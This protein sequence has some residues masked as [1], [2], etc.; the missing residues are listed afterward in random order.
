[1]WI[2]IVWLLWWEHQWIRVL[3]PV[4]ARHQHTKNLFF[5]MCVCVL[6]WRL[7]MRDSPH[8]CVCVQYKSSYITM[9]Q[10]NSETTVFISIHHEKLWVSPH[11]HELFRVHLYLFFQ[12]IDPETTA[13][14]LWSVMFNSFIIVMGQSVRG[15]LECYTQYY[16]VWIICIMLITIIIKVW[17]HEHDKGCY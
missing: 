12:D 15:L 11:T 1:M 13:N 2:D 9:S 3:I 16:C 10:T 17:R 4:S 5:Y 14:H 6:V 7:R 8:E